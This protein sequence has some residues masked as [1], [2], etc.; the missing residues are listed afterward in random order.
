MVNVGFREVGVVL[1]SRLSM[2]GFTIY[3]LSHVFSFFTF[4]FCPVR[5]VSSRRV[6]PVPT[7]LLPG[8]KRPSSG[9]IRRSAQLYCCCLL[10][11]V[12][13]EHDIALV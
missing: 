8:A 9:T 4:C 6:W 2:V 11:Q 13:G 5:Q 1:L 7:S 12:P 3:P 10:P